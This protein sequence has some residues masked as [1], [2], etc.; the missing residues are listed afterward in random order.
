[1]LNTRL[2]TLS[3]ITSLF[4]TGAVAAAETK[5]SHQFLIHEVHNPLDLPQVERVQ[6]R[7]LYRS[8]TIWVAAYP[9]IRL[10]TY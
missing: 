8:Q 5:A 9:H 4:L 1:M 2:L 10:E 6:S 7:Q 3:L